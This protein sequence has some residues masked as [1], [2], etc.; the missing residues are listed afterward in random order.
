MMRSQRGFGLIELLMALTVVSLLLMSVYSGYTTH[1]L[2]SRRTDVI[3]SLVH[4]QLRLEHCY[5]QESS[6]A[7]ECMRTTSYPHRSEMGFYQISMAHLDE[8]HYLLKATPVG[9]QTKD[10][11]CSVWTLSHANEKSAF[12]HSGLPETSCWS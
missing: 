11:L 2:K 4:E 3:L 8:A 9:P 7:G 12:N 10:E 6:Y 5:Y 1:L